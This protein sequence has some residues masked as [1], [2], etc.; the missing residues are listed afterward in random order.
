V[1]TK[2]KILLIDDD[3]WMIRV[4]LKIINNL[5]FSDVLVANNGFDAIAIAVKEVPDVIFL[6]LLMPELDGLNTLKLIRTIE[7]TSSIN[8]I[9]CSGNNDVQNFTKTVSLGANEYISKPF[10]ADIIKSK[11]EKILNITL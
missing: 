11:L 6:D 2:T 9:I 7:C 3:N 5:G 8:V 4:L 1:E 10:T